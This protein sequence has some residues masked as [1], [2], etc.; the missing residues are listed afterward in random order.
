M[1]RALK[2]V[3]LP[4]CP[5]LFAA[6]PVLSLYAQ[7]KTEVEL[8][9]LWP[10]LLACAT[11][12]VGLFAVLLLFTRRVATASV[13]STVVVVAVLYYGLLFDQRP[14]WVA[15]G[16]LVVASGAVVAALRTRCQLLSLVVVLA[17]GATV[18]V[19]PQGLSV[20]LYR[21]HH[22]PVAADDPRLWPST[23]SAPKAAKDA[24]TRPDIFVL[25]PDDYA[26]ADVLAQY[27]HYDN[28]EFLARLEQRGF[29]V[30]DQARSP[31]AYSELN[32]ASA[33]NLDYLTN[34]PKVVG[35]R[36]QDIQVVKRVMEDN[37]AARLLTSIGYDYVH[38][39][40]DEV[41]FAGGNPDISPFASPDSFAN[42]WLGKT[43]LQRVGG[44]LG[45][46]EPAMNDRFR[47]SIRSGFSELRSIRGGTRPKFVVF[48]T[49]MP[50][51]PYVF[52][53]DG[54]PVTFPADGD[55]T[56]RIGMQYYVEGL[57]YLNRQLLQSIDA[58]RANAKT[59]PVIVIQ[60]DEGFEVNPDLVGESTAEDIR[61]KGL[62]ALALPG[63]TDPGVPTP[64]NS[65]NTLRFVF[66]H[67]LGTQLPMLESR[68]HLEGDH[69]YDFTE[70]RVR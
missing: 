14:T 41:T 53:A 67:Y 21:A 6:F 65:V 22:A 19:L 25:M 66:N 69:P 39:D 51:D 11:G 47:H 13:A 28:S 10:S 36:S 50:H 31:Y 34:W 2:A 46:N 40:T 54:K 60:A 5:A 20:A 29:V 15:V 61:V 57:R 24:A 59:P 12:A 68:S 7:N 63:L 33:L 58:I 43:I 45:F 56:G 3:V 55:H 52:A 49:L 32:M 18:M 62:A 64:P 35:R 17:V 38:L 23:L 1:S 42:L 26:R 44:P 70:I 27:F 30:S 16:W 4:L 9:L 8:S 37:R 48:H